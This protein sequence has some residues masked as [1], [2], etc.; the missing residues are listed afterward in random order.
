LAVH[1][2]ADSNAREPQKA[3]LPDLHVFFGPALNPPGQM[4]N[5]EYLISLLQTKSPTPSNGLS[6]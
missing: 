5:Q 2:A 3:K 6:A 4:K 1:D